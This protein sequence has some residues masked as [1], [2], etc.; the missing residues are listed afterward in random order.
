MDMT[1]PSPSQGI[2][3]EQYVVKTAD[4]FQKLYY[5]AIDKRRHVS[6][7]KAHAFCI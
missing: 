7:K 1:G 3:D 6:D 4:Q 5:D 2:L